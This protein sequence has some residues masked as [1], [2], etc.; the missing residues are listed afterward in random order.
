M[1]RLSVTIALAAGL[2]T[3][4]V[5]GIPLGWAVL[6]PALTKARPAPAVRPVGP[7]WSITG[8]LLGGLSGP[9]AISG[10]RV[11]WERV[12]TPSAPPRRLDVSLVSALD[13]EWG[14]QAST[15]RTSAR[16]AGSEWP[17]PR[18][19][20]VWWDGGGPGCTIYG[21]TLSGPDVTEAALPE[22]TD[23]LR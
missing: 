15:R 8:S 7:E 22:E 3:T 6:G 19:L 12:A 2:A 14:H 21:V 4:V 1:L 18:S 20:S 10:S 5:V 17:E 13:G 23:A 16:V 11:T 9:G